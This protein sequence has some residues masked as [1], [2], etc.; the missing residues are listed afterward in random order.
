MPKT[1]TQETLLD[2]PA[3][4]QRYLNYTGVVGMSWIENIRLKYTGKFRQA[5]DKLWMP[6]VAY[7]SY[8]TDPASFSWNAKFKI[9]GIPLLR[10]TDKYENGK[11]SMLGKLAG[12]KTIFDVKE[13]DELNQ[14]AMMRY[15]NEIMW[16]PTAFFSEKISW[17][18]IDNESV[19]VTYTDFG[20]SV[21]A[22][23]LIDE[24]GQLTNFVAKR[25]RGIN[26]EFSLDIW[27][28]PITAYREF[29]GLQLPSQGSGVWN[30]PSG[31]LTYIILELKEIEYDLVA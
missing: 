3:P 21:S 31:D 26:D 20:M 10:V 17:Q 14:G 6:M 19:Q 16:F 29:A 2:L 15:L 1:I 7:E 22:Q 12:V 18:P 11:G 8:T 28:T 23:L 9:A 24:I 5:E 13:S 25:Y 4:I 27:S 30:L